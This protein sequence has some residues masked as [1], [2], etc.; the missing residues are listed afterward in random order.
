M[1]VETGRK[2]SL[3]ST[4]LNTLSP[5]M[6]NN[7]PHR[8]FHILSIK[9]IIISLF[10]NVFDPIFSKWICGYSISENI[11]AFAAISTGSVTM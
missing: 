1:Y 3:R 8:E 4:P 11:I 5:R 6:K 7:I 10:L 9:I 2:L